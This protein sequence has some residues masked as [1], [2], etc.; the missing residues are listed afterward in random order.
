[1]RK[2]VE[3]KVFWSQERSLRDH[4]SEAEIWSRIEHWEA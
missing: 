3:G 4:P 2:R 1:L